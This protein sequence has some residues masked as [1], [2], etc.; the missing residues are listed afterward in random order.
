M[1]CCMRSTLRTT[2]GATRSGRASD[3]LA[4]HPSAHSAL[5]QARHCPWPAQRSRADRT[6]SHSRI[7]PGLQMRAGG[8]SH[9]QP[10]MF[11]YPSIPNPS[12]FK[13]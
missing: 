2:L 5:R 3:D 8:D 4:R 9:W 11:K 6:P 7:H 10:L 13:Q 12:S 1:T